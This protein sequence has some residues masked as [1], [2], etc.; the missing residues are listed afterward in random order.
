[1]VSPNKKGSLPAGRRWL[2]RGL[3]L[4]VGLLLALLLL[5]AGLWIFG[6]DSL[7]P[8]KKQ[9]LV[10]HKPFARYYCY[11]SNP[12]QEFS[13][14]PETGKGKWTLYDYNVPPR[15]L[16]IK[17]LVDTPWCTEEKVSS[18]G[19]RDREFAREPPAGVLRIAGIGDSFA[20]G[21]G[22]PVQLSLF[23][24][25]ERELGQGF[26]V[27]NG[28]RPGVSTSAEVPLWFNLVRDFQ[29]TRTIVVFIIN[30]IELTP[31]LRERM[32]TVNDLINLRESRSRKRAA[33]GQL[34][35][36]KVRLLRL[37]ST[38]LTNRR[39]RDETIQWYRDMYSTEQNGQNLLNLRGAFGTM[40][41]AI[42]ANRTVLVLYPLMEGL[43][44]GYPFTRA[45]A[46]VKKLAEEVGLPTLDLAP[47]F[48]GFESRKLQVHPVDHHPNGRAHKIAA[49]AIV[50]WLKKGVPWFL[51][52]EGGQRR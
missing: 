35:L 24:Q 32:E 14:R 13:R 22:V 47:V 45:H 48:A 20:Q 19:L 31:K 17:R 36:R 49:Q 4:L 29:C 1:M 40:S 43:E 7:R 3:S 12:N 41:S 5:E 18:A 39:V 46:Q 26:E 52:Q 34:M 37:T 11:D 33:R 25:V 30:D 16:S 10:S 23:K 50:Y 8:G 9:L 27:I 44:S 2:F 21:E 15:K 38:W 42:P 6:P 51:K 28:A